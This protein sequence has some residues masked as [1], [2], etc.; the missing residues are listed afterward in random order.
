MIDLSTA[1]DLLDMG[2]RIG[3]GPRAEEQLEG[4]V[5][6]HNILERD[7]V[8]YLADEVGMGKTYVALGAL[9]LFRHFRP[10]FRVLILAPR[11]NIQQK[12]MKE[13]RNFVAHNV[14]F[15]DLRVRGVDDRPARPL[16]AC[17]NLTEFVRESSL[18]RERDFFLRLTSFSLPVSG[19]QSV[20]GDGRAGGRWQLMEPT[21]AE[22]QASVTKLN[23]AL[24]AERE[25][26]KATK[27]ELA[28]H[29]TGD[30]EKIVTDRLAPVVK[31]R[32]DAKAHAAKVAADWDAHRIDAAIGQA[33]GKC[34]MIPA[35]HEDAAAML[36][37]VLEVNKDGAV[38]TKAAANTIAGMTIEQHVHSVMKAARPH[39]WPPSS[40]GGASGGKHSGSGGDAAC[41]DPRS[42]KFSVTAQAQFE[43]RYGTDAARR[44][45]R[46][47]GG[48][49]A[50]EGGRR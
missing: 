41:F 46:Q 34:G 31:E 7:R 17:G 23:K 50:G 33:L 26:H 1:R 18:D 22:L 39:W 19:R 24:D 3:P 15:R 5:A 25:A 27:T 8:A 20:D 44:A 37:G 21:I 12:W 29:A 35:N 16:V 28:A 40:G 2:A 32:D 49:L 10:R 36:R 14:R 42:S 48:S 43:R 45:A 4:A 13:M 47:F 9:A 6:L 38:I 30:V 11:E